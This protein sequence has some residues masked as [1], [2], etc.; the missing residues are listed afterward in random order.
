MLNLLDIFSKKIRPS[1]SINVDENKLH[2]IMSIFIA[3]EKNHTGSGTHRIA[4]TRKPSLERE[5][6]S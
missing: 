1:I 4:V 2:E 6:A 3:F 5:S